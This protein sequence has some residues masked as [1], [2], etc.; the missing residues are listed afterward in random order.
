LLITISTVGKPLNVVL[1]C[2]ETTGKFRF[3]TLLL[4]SRVVQSMGIVKQ[5]AYRKLAPGGT[6]LWI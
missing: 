1:N 5:I 6:G 2:T 3:F 4:N